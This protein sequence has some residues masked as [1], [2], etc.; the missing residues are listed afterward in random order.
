MDWQKL[1]VNISPIATLRAYNQDRTYEYD[2]LCA[3][4]PCPLKLKS[5]GGF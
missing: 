5:N 3:F 1:F 4:K 2:M